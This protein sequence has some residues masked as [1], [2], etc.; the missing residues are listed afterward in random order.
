MKKS[1]LTFSILTIFCLFSFTGCFNIFD[2]F[3]YGDTKNDPKEEKRY[4]D[5]LKTFKWSFGASDYIQIIDKENNLMTFYQQGGRFDDTQF[6]GYYIVRKDGIL[7]LR[8]YSKDYNV[9]LQLK[10]ESTKAPDSPS[11]SIKIGKLIRNGEQPTFTEDWI[12]ITS[13]GQAYTPPTSTETS[14]E[15][16]TNAEP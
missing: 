12:P 5:I 7:V 13:N 8:N 16:T 10:S 11:V 14:P 2:D 4:E 1:L 6:D 9:Y 3:L 15:T